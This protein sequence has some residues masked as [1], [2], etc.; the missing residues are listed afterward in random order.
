MQNG[1]CVSFSVVTA[2]LTKEV[3]QRNEN[4]RQSGL[5][6]NSRD[7]RISRV[8][9]QGED[10]YTHVYFAAPS[11]NMFDALTGSLGILIDPFRFVVLGQRI[12]FKAYDS[13]FPTT[14]SSDTLVGDWSLQWA[15]LVME[16]VCELEACPSLPP[17][18]LPPLPPTPP[19][20]PRSPPSPPSPPS[21]PP[22]PPSF[23][24]S[25]PCDL[26]ASAW[27]EPVEAWGASDGSVV[28]GGGRCV[29]YELTA[30][31]LSAADT[32]PLFLL[33][34]VHL[35]DG[36]G[37]RGEE[38]RV[39]APGE[40]WDNATFSPRSRHTLY[41]GGAL[42]TVTQ[43]AM[44]LCNASS[45]YPFARAWKDAFVPSPPSMPLSSP[46]GSAP[47]G[48]HS[49]N[50]LHYLPFIIAGACALLICAFELA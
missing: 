28:L 37:S 6:V 20:P 29:R 13:C 30:L 41:P 40:A 25:P 45:A 11:Q 38:W 4:D 3:L 8:T 19:M 42:L 17:P 46:P 22:S 7:C 44:R 39:L 43:G 14:S 16:K 21:Y 36:Q 35:Q 10:G 1:A 50:L 32:S 48:T 31:R 12:N 33:P 27:S 5:Q 9:W 34:T 49:F 24:P 47:T 23:P 2:T 26:N 18:P 15:A